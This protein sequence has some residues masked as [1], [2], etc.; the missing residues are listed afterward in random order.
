[1]NVGM[2]G[3]VKGR[4]RNVGNYAN[5]IARTNLGGPVSGAWS[6]QVAFLPGD[7]RGGYPSA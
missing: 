6:V 1:M 3:D 2:Y 4:R 5:K 7:Y